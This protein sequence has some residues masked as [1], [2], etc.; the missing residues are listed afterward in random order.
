MTNVKR[1]LRFRDIICTALLNAA[2]APP[3]PF[4]Y[5]G[6]AVIEGVMMRGRDHYAVA[7]RAPDG[8]ITVTSDLL[9]SRV[10]TSRVW[11]RPFLRGVAGLYEMFNLGLKALRWS[12]GIQ[13]GE[14]IEISPMA[15]RMTVLFSVV[16]GLFLF[17]GLPL[18]GGQLLH[19]TN[20]RS[21]VTILIEGVLRAGVLLAYL[22]VIGF[23]PTV[24]RLF[25]YHGAEHKAINCLESG[26]AVDVANTRSSSRLHPRCGTGFI[27]VV[28]FVSIIVFSPLAV[29]FW[30]IRIL[31][32][33]ALVPVVAG[34]AYE[35]I[36]LL[37][38]IRYTE[39]GRVA[40]API[41]GAQLLSTREPDDA[42]IEVSIAALAAARKG[43]EPVA[44]MHGS[45]K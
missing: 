20:T 44:E 3:A 34:I 32:Q 35:L 9:R 5:G 37:V 13:L 30:P 42:Q 43:E 22:L 10:Y 6:Q 8:S 45:G 17:I 28:A 11:S 23:I 36:R 14:E 26:A 4:F 31:L 2:N 18:I 39:L 38:K 21:L 40:L 25:Q 27:V 1:R 7:A 29:F 15:M 41:L 19:S 33:I 12:A 24:N 16:F